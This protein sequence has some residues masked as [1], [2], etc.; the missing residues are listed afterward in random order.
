MGF[1]TNMIEKLLNKS[2]ACL[3]P[4]A[5]APFKDQRETYISMLEVPSEFVSSHHDSQEAF[6]MFSSQT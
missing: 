4:Q 5:Q 6:K 2:F 1:E 3:S